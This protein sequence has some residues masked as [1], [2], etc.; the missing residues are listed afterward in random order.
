MAAHH[1]SPFDTL[2]RRPWHNSISSRLPSYVA[3][4][5]AYAHGEPSAPSSSQDLE[6]QPLPPP[7]LAYKKNRSASPPALRAASS[8]TLRRR[9][10]LCDLIE[11][12]MKFSHSI[13]FNAVPDW[14]SNYISY[15]NLKKLIYQLEKQLHQNGQ[16]SASAQDPESSPLLS[17]S[18]DDPDKVF[19][20]KLDDELEKICSFYQ[21]KELEI[22]GEVDSLLRDVEEFQAEHE[23]GEDDEDGMRRQSVWARARQNSIFRSFQMPNKRRRTSTSGS[24]R[25]RTIEEEDSD[26]DDNE[27]TALNKSQASLDRRTNTRTTKDYASDGRHNSHEF[28]ASDFRRR[29]STAFNDFG[30]DA[31]QALYDEGI[32]LKKRI[33][34]LY[35]NVCEL[36]SFIQLNETGFNKVIKKYDKILDRK[37]KRSYIDTKVKPSYPFQPTTMEHLSERLQNVEEAYATIVTK[38]DVEAARQ[39]LRL[40]LREHVV[41]ERNTVWREMIGIERKAQAANLGIRNTMLGQDTDPKKARLQG[42][43]EDGA[44]KE[45]STPIGRYR[46]PK[47]LVSGTFWVLVAVVAIFAVLL[48]VPIMEKPEQQN[49]LALVVFVSLLWATEVRASQM[50]NG[51]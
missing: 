49:C 41:W 22:F 5:H 27:H 13:Q 45:V 37:L 23:A 43:S 6:L 3:S 16:P 51:D 31:L 48:A 24:G 39:E 7:R 11:R 28:S 29:P 42:D 38:G 15:S 50:Q 12:D 21:L 35:V 18:V 44:L 34:N 2:D 9:R 40:H 17:S 1:I 4:T 20:R 19:T 47:P 36:R 8:A 10:K 26:D 32:T 46:C 25:E 30:D 33:T 14:S